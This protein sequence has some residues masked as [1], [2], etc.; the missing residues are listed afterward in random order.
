MNEKQTNA[1]AYSVLPKRSRKTLRPSRTRDRPNLDLGQTELCI[2]CCVY[3][4]T[5][6]TSAS[7]R[8]FFTF[9]SPIGTYC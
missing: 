8:T 5:L 2:F 4:I 6:Q 9:L 3:D 1:G 7:C